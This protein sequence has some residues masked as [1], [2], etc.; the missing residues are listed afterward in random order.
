M[1]K[2]TLRIQGMHCTN[3][4]M[5]IDMDLEDLVGVKEAKTNYARSL[6]QVEYDPARVS[7]AQILATIRET[8][9]EAQPM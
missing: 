7:L 3:C 5:A 2:Q 9:Y 4:A 1:T 6:T 8:G